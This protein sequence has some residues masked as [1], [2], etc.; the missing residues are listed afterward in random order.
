MTVIAVSN[1]TVVTD[2]NFFITAPA[3]LIIIVHNIPDDAIIFGNNLRQK[4]ADAL[5]RVGL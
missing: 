2:N 3:A 4:R 1:S 5:L